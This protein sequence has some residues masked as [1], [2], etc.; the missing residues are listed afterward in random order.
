ME[1]GLTLIRLHGTKLTD[2]R[3][4]AIKEEDIKKDTNY[5]RRKIQNIKQLQDTNEEQKRKKNIRKNKRN[6]IKQGT[7]NYQ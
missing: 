6:K 7:E 4:A 2:G 5:I 1:S 3:R